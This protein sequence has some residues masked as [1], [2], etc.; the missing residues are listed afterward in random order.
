MSFMQPQVVWNFLRNTEK[1][2]SLNLDH[3]GIFIGF[4]LKHICQHYLVPE[5]ERKG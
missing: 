3:L 2:E 4:K 5:K 1:F